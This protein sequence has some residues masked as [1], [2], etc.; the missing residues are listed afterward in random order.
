MNDFNQFESQNKLPNDPLALILA[1]GS[2]L[3]VILGC[4]CGLFTIIPGIIL[5]ITAWILSSKSL[6]TYNSSQGIYSATSFQNTKTARVLAI[7]GTVLNGIGLFISILF[8][9]GALAQPA[10]L[11]EYRQQLENFESHNNSFDNDN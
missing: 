1:I 8:L 7:I 2:I 9:I 5:G 10:F 3:F 4:C 11:E 6:Q